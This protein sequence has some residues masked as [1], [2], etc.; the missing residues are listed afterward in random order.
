M[1]DLPLYSKDGKSAG[2]I[3]VD[4]KLFGDKVKK[5]LLHQVV[6]IHEAN[7]REGNAHTKT[8]GEVEGSTKKPW[9]QK[10][11]G[12]ARAGTKRS[13]IW[14]HGGIVF[15]PRKREYRMTITDSMRHAAL[16]SALL[17]KIKDKEV[18]II[19][20][21]ELPKPK[22]KEMAKLMKAIGFKRTVLLAI[23]KYNETVWLSAR[24]LQDLS[25]RPVNELNAY[26]VLKHKDLLLTKEALE[27]LVKS[28]SGQAAPTPKKAEAKKP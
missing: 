2:T 5:K 16:D 11:T 22:T 20:A 17:G 13:P 18:S 3:A 23:P 6:V 8:R 4:E 27:A 12:M 28:R 7:Q 19:E 15:G 24:N 25:V 1:A 14:R 10:H 26:D 9:P 21:V